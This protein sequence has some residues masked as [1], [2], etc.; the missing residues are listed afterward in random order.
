M[1]WVAVRA[2]CLHNEQYGYSLADVPME[3]EESV[4]DQTWVVGL[5]VAVGIE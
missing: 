1:S 2:L 4:V 5:G 3:S